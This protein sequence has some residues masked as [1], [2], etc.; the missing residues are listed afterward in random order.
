MTI[1]GKI[2]RLLLYPMTIVVG[3]NFSATILV[4]WTLNVDTLFRIINAE[5]FSFEN[6]INCT[7][8]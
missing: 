8:C 2:S 3:T 5:H 6:N 4:Y 1:I 7:E